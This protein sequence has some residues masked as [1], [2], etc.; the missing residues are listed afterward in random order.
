MSISDKARRVDIIADTLVKKF[1]AP[2]SWKFFCRCGWGLNDD[3]IWSIYE[4]AHKPGI[5][6][7]LKYF[8]SL[9]IIRMENG[10]FSRRKGQLGGGKDKSEH[11]GSIRSL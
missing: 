8:I 1:D 9:A 6:N 11:N 7:P 10:A 2:G 3:E 4:Q 5:K